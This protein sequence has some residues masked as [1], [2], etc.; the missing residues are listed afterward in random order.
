[1]GASIGILVAYV[2]IGNVV[3]NVALRLLNGELWCTYFMP[4]AI[5]IPMSTM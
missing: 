4:V 3:L 2:V 1:M 5:P